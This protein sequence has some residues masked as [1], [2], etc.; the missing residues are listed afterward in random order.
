MTQFG[1]LSWSMSLALSF[2]IRLGY[3]SCSPNVNVISCMWI[4]KHKTI[5]N[6]SFM[7]HKAL[8]IV[9]NKSELVGIDC[10]ETLSLVIKPAT[11]RQCCLVGLAHS[12]S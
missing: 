6:G 8:L 9:D 7:S 1:M 11:I 2:K 5:Y 12:S 3:W 10:D 4:L